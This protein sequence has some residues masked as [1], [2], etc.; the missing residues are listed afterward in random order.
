MFPMNKKTEKSRENSLFR[1]IRG[2][3]ITGLLV[4]IPIFITLWVTWWIYEKLTAWAIWSAENI[5][6]LQKY[7]DS[8][9]MQHSIR[10]LSLLVIVTV[11]ILVGQFARITVGERLIHF[12]QKLLLHLPIISFIYSTCKQVGDAIGNSASGSMFSKVVM[13]EYPNKGSYAIGFVTNENQESFEITEKIG[14]PVISVF[15]P[16]T[17]NPTSGFLFL[18]PRE[19]CTFLNMSVSD[20]MKFIVSVGAVIPSGNLPEECKEAQKQEKNNF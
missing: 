6:V 20:A 9:W 10:I 15:M 5:P 14:S 16:T 19:R 2:F 8:F 4:L 18:L 13:F 12:A 7:T 3:F 17:P 1:K 11:F